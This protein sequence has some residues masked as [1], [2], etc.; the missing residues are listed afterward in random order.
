M[1]T[2]VIFVSRLMLLSKVFQT[3]LLTTQCMDR[4]KM[5]II[6]VI[7]MLTMAVTVE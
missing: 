3:L 4:L 1:V 5:M 6:I 7:M 2:D